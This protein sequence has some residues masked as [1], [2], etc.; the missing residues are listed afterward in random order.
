MKI[1]SDPDPNLF[2]SRSDTEPDPDMDEHENQDPDP[3]KVGTDPQHCQHLS[4]AA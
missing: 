4:I 3:N 1:L 2:E